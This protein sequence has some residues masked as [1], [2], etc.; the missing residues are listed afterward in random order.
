MFLE[1]NGKVL[2]VGRKTK[3]NNKHKKNKMNTQVENT[4]VMPETQTAPAAPKAKLGRKPNPNRLMQ[5]R[6]NPDGSVCGRGKPNSKNSY[7]IVKIKFHNY[8]KGTIVTNDQ[9]VEVVEEISPVNAAVIQQEP[10]LA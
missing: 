5:V 9:I 10:V 3:T 6:I 8:T 4:V 1:K 7:R 2:N